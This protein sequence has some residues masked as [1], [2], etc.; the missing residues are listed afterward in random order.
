MTVF[1][2]TKIKKLISFSGA[3]FV[4]YMRSCPAALAARQL[5]QAANDGRYRA[6]LPHAIS[7]T[8]LLFSR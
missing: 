6:V 7:D 5:L 3:T 2:D 1:S 8:P 4:C